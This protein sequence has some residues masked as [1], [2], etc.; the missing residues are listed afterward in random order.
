M[1]QS[2]TVVGGRIGATIA[3]FV[4]PQLNQHLGFVWAMAGLAGLSLLGA[5]LSQFL[6]PETTSRSLEEINLEMAPAK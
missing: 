3:A 1:A 4:F 6:V 5:V 2:I